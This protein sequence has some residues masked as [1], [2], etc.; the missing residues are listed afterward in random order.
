MKYIKYPSHINSFTAIRKREHEKKYLQSTIKEFSFIFIYFILF[1]IFIQ[2]FYIHF[3]MFIL[4][5]KHFLLS[6]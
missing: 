2:F 1:L 6:V 5:L 4:I 3:I